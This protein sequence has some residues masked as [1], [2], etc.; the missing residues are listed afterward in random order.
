VTYLPKYDY[1][2]EGSNAN[3]AV[4]LMKIDYNNT[5]ELLDGGKQ[6]VNDGLAVTYEALDGGTDLA[7]TG[8]GGGKDIALSLAS[9]PVVFGERILGFQDPGTSLD[10]AQ[11]H[12]QVAFEGVGRRWQ[13]SRKADLGS[14]VLMLGWDMPVL[15]SFIPGPKGNMD[16]PAATVISGGINASS[17][18]KSDDRDEYT[19]LAL[20][21]NS[22]PTYFAVNNRDTAT[23]VILSMFGGYK[24]RE[25]EMADQVTQNVKDGSVVV[26]YSHSGG[27]SRFSG[28]S[29]YLGVAG[30]G[31]RALAAD[32]GPGFG[33]YN[34]I[35]N[36]QATYSAGL[37]D[38]TSLGGALMSWGYWAGGATEHSYSGGNRQG[39]LNTFLGDEHR[40]DGCPENMD[41]ASNNI[42]NENSNK[43][44][45]FIMQN[46]QR[47]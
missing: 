28:A 9:L 2:S 44:Y 33:Y 17:I 42:G 7:I 25:L 5:K 8:I 15:G 4:T 14:S 18:R 10:Y 40:Q 11:K 35:E 39:L 46:I 23:R 29:K 41:P 27:V 21:D 20:P 12:L 13:F 16:G 32:Q 19:T 3:P 36:L 47:R 37:L 6:V 45:N 31:V 34:N 1:S 38:P 26:G 43:N 30:I 24:G 22:E